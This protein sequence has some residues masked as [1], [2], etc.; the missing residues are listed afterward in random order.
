MVVVIAWDEADHGGDR[1]RR[2]SRAERCQQ[3][4]EGG[5][6]VL[7][8]TQR[9]FEEV[10]EYDQLRRITPAGDLCKTLAQM[11]QD[12]GDRRLIDTVTVGVDRSEHAV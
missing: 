6:G 7:G 1:A 10:A 5:R 3:M 11:R 12:R 8:G 2:R 9:Q 4:G